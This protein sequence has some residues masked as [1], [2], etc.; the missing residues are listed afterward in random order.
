MKTKTSWLRAIG[1]YGF[2]VSL[3]GCA[4]FASLSGEQVVPDQAKMER[5]E[6]ASRQAGLRVVWINPPTKRVEIP[7]Q[8]PS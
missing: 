2:L 8:R 5:I 4:S 1:A 3:S 7:A 6:R